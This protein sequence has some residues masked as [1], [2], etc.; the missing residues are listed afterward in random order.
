MTLVG[1]LHK[2]GALL[3]LFAIS[4]LLGW[5]EFRLFMHG[6]TRVGLYLMLA[7]VTVGLI[8]G[9]VL[10]WLTVRYKTWS[11]N[12][13]PIYAF[14]QGVLVGAIS[15]EADSRYPGITVQAVCVTITMSCCLLLAYRVGWIRVTESFNRKLAVAISGV[16][17]FYLANIAMVLMGIPTLTQR[18]GVIPSILLSVVVVG[19]AGMSLISNFDSAAQCVNEGNPKYMEW[20]AA[21]GL[22]VALV[23]LYVE[24]LNLLDKTRRAEEG[25][26]PI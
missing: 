1:T 9:W 8:G 24:V 26:E 15:A 17:L 5:N 6:P 10:V 14:V 11:S 23:W 25:A 16:V 19:I 20:Y 4:M 13:A 12:T 22:V 2:T 7:I 21:L 3:V 18:A